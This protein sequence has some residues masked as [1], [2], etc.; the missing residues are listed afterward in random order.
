MN[1]RRFDIT[2]FHL[3]VCTQC[4]ERLQVKIHWSRANCTAPW[5]RN[6][7]MS[8]TRQHG[9]EHIKARPHFAHLIVRR[10]GRGELRRI[11]PTLAI[12][13]RPID[14]DPKAREQLAQEARIR[15]IWHIGE[16]QRLAREQASRHEF[17]S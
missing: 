15:Q 9:S 5:K 6:R 3:E 8:F 7:R 17:Q 1:G 11:Q 12:T 13:F 4:F 10:D 14:L 2:F 16:R